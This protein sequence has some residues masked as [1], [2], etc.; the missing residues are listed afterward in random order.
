[1]EGAGNAVNG[2]LFGHIGGA[3]GGARFEAYY[4]SIEHIVNETILDDDDHMAQWRFPLSEDKNG[5]G[6]LRMHNPHTRKFIQCLDVLIEQ[7]VVEDVRRQKWIKA[8][9]YHRAAMTICNSMKISKMPKLLNIK[10]NADHFFQEWVEL[11]GIRG[12]TSH[13][14]LAGSGHIANFLFRWRNL[15]RHSQQGWEALNNLVKTFAHRRTQ[16]GGNMGSGNGAHKSMLLP[17]GRWLQRRIFW[18]LGNSIDGDDNAAYAGVE[19]EN[20]H[21]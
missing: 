19:E 13:I 20:V 10:R 12:M 16:L 17:V 4:Q 3:V 1:M 11:H 9:E 2:S 18:V 7:C 8:V 6:Q 14:H 5:V 21:D 15:Y